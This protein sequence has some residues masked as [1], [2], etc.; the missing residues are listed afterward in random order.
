MSDVSCTTRLITSNQ[1]PFLAGMVA[2]ELIQTV[3]V[4]LSFT[5]IINKTGFLVG[6]LGLNG[7][8]AIAVGVVAKSGLGICDSNKTVAACAVGFFTLT[9]LL[10]LI[11]LAG[12]MHYK[13]CAWA[14]TGFSIFLISGLLTT[15]G[16]KRCVEDKYAV[17]L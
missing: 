1:R 9:S 5:G 10:P 12:G 6:I 2:A 7:V 11:S 3:L 14:L 16:C 4:V 8:K 15:Y 17:N 13:A